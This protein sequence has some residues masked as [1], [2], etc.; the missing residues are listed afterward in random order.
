MKTILQL[1]SIAF[2]LAIGCA[3]HAQ[4]TNGDFEAGFTSGTWTEASTN[5]GSP[6]CDFPSCGN[7]GGPCVANSGAF[8]VWFGG[9]GGSIETASVEQSVTIPT[10]TTASINLFVKIAQPG[11]GL[12]TDRLE[13][14]ADNIVL[15]TITSHDSVT[16]ENY[17]LVSVDVSSLADGNAH[18]LKIEGFQTSTEIF[19]ILVD[20]VTL[21]VDGATVVGIFEEFTEPTFKVYPNPATNAINLSFGEISG[22]AEI[23]ILSMDGSIVSTELV[24]DVFKKDFSFTTT[25]MENGIYVVQVRN[26]DTTTTQRIV[27]TK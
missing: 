17:A 18:A 13:V 11:P 15:T 16:Y 22:E 27:V 9:A 12:V 21:M 6:L 1:S 24:S 23:T 25:N 7:G 2:T 14:S 4:I 10:G 5:F 19:N 3:T 26:N 20:D 8:F